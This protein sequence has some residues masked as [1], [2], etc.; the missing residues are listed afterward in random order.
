[1]K[2]VFG[3]CGDQPSLKLRAWQANCRTN[4]CIASA[5]LAGSLARSY[6]FD[7]LSQSSRVTFGYEK[8]SQNPVFNP[9]S[10]DLH[11]RFRGR[12]AELCEDG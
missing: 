11:S 10:R 9:G 4:R 5:S 7:W 8:L 12:Q 3:I 1:M 6:L 2:N